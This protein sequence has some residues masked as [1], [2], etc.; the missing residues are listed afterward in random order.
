MSAIGSASA[1][2]PEMWSDMDC[3]TRRS[4]AGFV[5]QRL[6][7]RVLQRLGRVGGIEPLLERRFHPLSFAVLL[8]GPAVVA[9]VRRSALLRA[10]DERL[11]RSKVGKTVV[12]DRMSEDHVEQGQGGA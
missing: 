3:S 10:G 8:H 12:T 1:R 5:Q 11:H 2:G 9:R 4:V 6:Q 7:R